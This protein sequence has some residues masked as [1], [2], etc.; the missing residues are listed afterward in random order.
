[1]KKFSI[2][3]LVNAVDQLGNVVYKLNDLLAQQT[4]CVTAAEL[5]TAALA[6]VKNNS[7]MHVNGLLH[8]SKILHTHSNICQTS[9]LFFFFF[10]TF[11]GFLLKLQQISDHAQIW[12]QLCFVLFC[13][14]WGCSVFV[15]AKIIATVRDWSSNPLW[16]ACLSTLGTTLFQVINECTSLFS[17]SL[18]LVLPH[19]QPPSAL[20]FFLP[21]LTQ[22]IVEASC[23]VWWCPGFV[24][25]AENR[26]IL[27]HQ[28][29]HLQE[30]YT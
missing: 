17:N 24:E 18:F 13:V 20:P 29:C 27:L 5:R 28:T 3:A 16:R 22:K 7:H 26:V 4:T 19:S 12:G 21:P 25:T 30:F 2:K 8:Y 1:M 15:P 23:F 10:F 14:G 6:Q 11:C 9:S